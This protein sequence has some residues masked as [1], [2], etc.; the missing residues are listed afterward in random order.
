MSGTPD[1]RLFSKIFDSSKI[2]TLPLRCGHVLKM[3]RTEL[4]NFFILH[5]YKTGS[6]P[7]PPRFTITQ[8]GLRQI[9][10]LRDFVPEAVPYGLLPAG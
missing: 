10:R 3:P 8:D 5:F 9:V 1:G 4:E 7:A 2:K 6:A